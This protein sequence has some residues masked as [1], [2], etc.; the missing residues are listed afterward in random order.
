MLAIKPFTYWKIALGKYQK[1]NVE[2][3]SGLY[4]IKVLYERWVGQHNL[5]ICR[6]SHFLTAYIIKL[7][8]AGH[9]N[10]IT[11]MKNPFYPIS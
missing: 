11:Y 9:I 7:W 10:I 2:R 4:Q 6:F 3:I 8:T 1:N 5:E